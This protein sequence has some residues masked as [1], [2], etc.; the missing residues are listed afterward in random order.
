MSID[1]NLQQQGMGPF[2]YP[3]SQPQAP[4]SS[5][6]GGYY[7]TLAKPN[8]LGSE[9]YTS[10]AIPALPDPNTT[11]QKKGETTAQ[12]QRRLAAT[13][14]QSAVSANYMANAM[15]V[16]RRAGIERNVHRRN[17]A[18]EGYDQRL[19]DNRGMMDY[20]QPQFD[21]AQNA[22]TQQLSDSYGQAQTGFLDRYNRNMGMVDQ[23]GNSQRDD[24][25]KKY[26]E[27]LGQSNQQAVR[28]G[29]G[30]TTVASA[31]NRGVT[32][33]YNRN[34]LALEDQLFQRRQAADQQ[35]SG[36]YLNSIMGG[37][38]AVSALRNTNLQ[39]QTQL[40]Q[41]NLSRDSALSGDRL[42]FL[43]SYTDEYP[44]LAD[45]SN[46]YLQSGVLEETKKTRAN[47]TAT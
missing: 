8:T 36:D 6:Y 7:G 1:V 41:A 37:G 32:H 45:I 40:Q 44:T 17:T 22:N 35:L 34:N 12:Y 5:A 26:A 38:A 4:A 33:D 10:V 25:A 24:L 2:Q 11:G 18:L 47:A 3:G 13:P 29:L 16:D 14:S 20:Y 39:N 19:A 46:L 9:T 28:R 30:N 31:L 42:Q 27:Q 21:A 23:Y 15:E 43:S